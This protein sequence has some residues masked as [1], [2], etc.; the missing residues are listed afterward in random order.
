[1]KTIIIDGYEC[2]YEVSRD[3]YTDSW[4]QFYFGY[5]M[6]EEAYGFLYRK[7]R[8]V[9]VPKKLFSLDFDIESTD[10]S[11]EGLGKKF[12]MVNIEKRLN[13]C[14]REESGNPLN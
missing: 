2:Q 3:G 4:T 9:L 14:D 12:A 8:E 6:V 5:E 7:R 1:M 10:V 11:V 13:E